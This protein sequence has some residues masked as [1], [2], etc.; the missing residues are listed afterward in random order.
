[1]RG[2]TPISPDFGLTTP[3]DGPETPRAT[4]IRDQY[5][6]HKFKKTY[7]TSFSSLVNQLTVFQDE[8][9]RFN[10]IEQELI[11]EKSST[12]AGFKI[13]LGTGNQD[14]VAEEI[15]LEE[16][17]RK[18]YIFRDVFKGTGISFKLQRICKVNQEK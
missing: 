17:D 4:K 8:I 3:Y 14:H 2:L 5:E 16:L 1:M 11:D 15:D 12:S 6:R 10:I 9:V 7:G 13:E 18:Q